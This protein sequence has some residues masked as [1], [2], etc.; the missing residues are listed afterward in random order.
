MPGTVVAAAAPRVTDSSTVHPPQR[1]AMAGTPAPQSTAALQGTVL[2]TKGR[3]AAQVSIGVGER[4]QFASLA[5]SDQNGRFAVPDPWP[6]ESI[7][8]GAPWRELAVRPPGHHA[9]AARAMGFCLFNNVAIA[10]RYIQKHY[11]LSRVLIVDWDVHHGNGTQHSFAQD[12]SI[13]FF[14]T[15]QFPHYPGTGHATERGTGAGEGSAIEV[16]IG[17]GIEVGLGVGVAS[18]F[19]FGIGVGVGVGIGVGVG[20]GVG[21]ER[22]GRAKDVGAGKRPAS[23]R[24]R[25]AQPL[26]PAA[27]ATMTA[28]AASRAKARRLTRGFGIGGARR[29]STRGARIAPATSQECA[30]TIRRSAGA[31]PKLSAACR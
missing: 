18:G 11:G 13:L 31:T 26:A 8:V 14:S 3:P 10:A 1:T 29:D 12:P 6:A 24:T 22:G 17:I 20:V 7:V 4:I 28:A 9:E 5:V 15:H 19:G 23:R 16:E 25:P 27:L 2:D 21:V 30:A